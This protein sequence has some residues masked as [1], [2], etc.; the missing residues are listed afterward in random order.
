M[1]YSTITKKK[2][3]CGCDKWPTLGYNGYFSSHAPQE[4]KDKVG[5]KRD[6]ARKN[7]NNKLAL[8]RKLHEVQN[9]VSG[10]ELNR[11]FENRRAEMV[12]YC[13]N[14]GMPS[15]KDNDEFYRCSIAHLLP[16]VYFPSVKTHPSNWLEL[17]FWGEKSCHTNMDNKMIDLIDMH[18]W[19]TIVQRFVAMYPSIADNEKRRIPQVLLNYIEVEK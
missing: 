1:A 9:V 3:K 17:C 4:I 10:A 8:G 13:D 6:V 7:H 15:C 16:K 19:E 11:W 14:C 18:C 12:G 5:S 2:C